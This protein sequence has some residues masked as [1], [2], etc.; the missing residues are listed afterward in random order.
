MWKF[1]LKSYIFLFFFLV[2][3][4]L[5]WNPKADKHDMNMFSEWKISSVVMC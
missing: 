2:V 3:F 1:V 4:L 5:H